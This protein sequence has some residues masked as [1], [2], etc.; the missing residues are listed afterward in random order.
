MADPPETPCFLLCLGWSL[1]SNLDYLLT[2]FSLALASVP[3]SSVTRFQLNLILFLQFL[4][5]NCWKWNINMN[6][7]FL[8][9]YKDLEL[10]ISLRTFLCLISAVSLGLGEKGSLTLQVDRV[11]VNV[12]LFISVVIEELKSALS[13]SNGEVKRKQYQVTMISTSR[14]GSHH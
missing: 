3:S 12:Y 8:W 6:I 4:V 1:Q 10:T 11:W 2:F 13:D 5:L 9:C 7:Y 14:R